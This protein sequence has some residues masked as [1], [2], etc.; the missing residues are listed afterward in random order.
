MSC[1]SSDNLLTYFAVGGT[2]STA[3]AASSGLYEIMLNFI[4]EDTHRDQDPVLSFT[5][6]SHKVT[7]VRGVS[8]NEHGQDNDS[9][10]LGCVEAS[11]DSTN[12]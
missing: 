4:Q 11:S 2:S 9:V 7:F 10:Y 1:N 8:I 12:D 5:E 3:P 6:M